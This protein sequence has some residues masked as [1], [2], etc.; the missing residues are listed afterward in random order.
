[1][2]V[3]FDNSSL[4]VQLDTLALTKPRIETATGDEV[5]LIG[6]F[7]AVLGVPPY[8]VGNPTTLTVSGTAP[9]Y[10]IQLGF[11]SAAAE[12]F[13]DW[14]SVSPLEAP[15]L[16]APLSSILKPTPDQTVLSRISASQ[17][18][19]PDGYTV[20]VIPGGEE[21]VDQITLNYCSNS[22]ASEKLR[23]DGV[24]SR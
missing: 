3:L 15:T 11:G 9:Y 24:R 13:T 14:G 7:P 23:M 5:K 4:S 8:L 20:A 21:V 18:D 19:V 22:Y 1:V 10:P 16:S 2:Q 6:G 17:S 12:N